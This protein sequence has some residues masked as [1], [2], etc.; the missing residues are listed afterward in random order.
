MMTMMMRVIIMIAINSD[1]RMKKMNGLARL[2]RYVLWPQR[3][4]VVSVIVSV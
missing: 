4:I 3:I 2:H 1:K